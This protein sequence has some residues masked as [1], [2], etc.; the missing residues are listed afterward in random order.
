[1]EKKNKNVK[2]ADKIIRTDYPL[3]GTIDTYINAEL[4]EMSNVEAEIKA[5]KQKEQ[6][7]DKRDKGK[8]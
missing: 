1:M 8:T 7:K 3:I 4:G 5:M 6:I 2:R